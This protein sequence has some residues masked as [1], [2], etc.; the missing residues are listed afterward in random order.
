M[1]DAEK[2]E[3]LLRSR[4]KG[5]WFQDS[6]P[7]RLRASGGVGLVGEVSIL[8]LS[9]PLSPPKPLLN[10]ESRS[11]EPGSGLLD[12]SNSA[13]GLVVVV[14]VVVVVGSNCSGGSIAREP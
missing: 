10:V 13:V 5:R 1:G 8:L 4:D 11:G 9:F 12:V 3:R 6:V 14:G 7:V 2:R